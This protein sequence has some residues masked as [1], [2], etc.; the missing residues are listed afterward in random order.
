MVLPLT[1]LLL[2]GGLK[3]TDVAMGT[4][5]A[6]RVGDYITV[7][8]TGTLTNGKQFDS[9]VG[10]APFSFV[11][12]AGSVIKGWDQGVVGMK[13]GGKRKLTI[14][15]AL[16]YGAAGAPPDIPANATLLFDVT[17]RKI[18]RVTVKVTKKG[19]GPA[20]KGRDSVAVLY[21]GRLT[22]GTEFDS[23]AKHGN[24]PI[25]FTIGQPGLIPGFS[26]GTLGMKLGE[27]R[28]VTIPYTLAYG[29]A[30]RPPVI[31]AKAD[32]IFDLELVTLNGKGR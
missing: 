32:L 3:K 23:S 30:G 4:G 17:M 21:A 15:G 11:L 25:P 1:A 2:Q 16:G 19:S 22:N 6:A 24:Q 10:K 9:S 20:V 31:P 8:Y 18:A 13:V 27:K 28:T 26:C 12:G 14:P 29:D 7:D 5:L